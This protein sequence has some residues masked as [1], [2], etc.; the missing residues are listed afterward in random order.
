[1]MKREPFPNKTKFEIFLGQLK[2]KEDRVRDLTDRWY[3]PHRHFAGCK[4]ERLELKHRVR[5]K[6]V[7]WLRRNRDEA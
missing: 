5:K 7:K 1:M 3:H 4:K 2:S 6:A